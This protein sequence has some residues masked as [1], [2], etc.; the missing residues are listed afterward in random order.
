LGVGATPHRS[1]SSLGVMDKRTVASVRVA[2]AITAVSAWLL[3]PPFPAPDALIGDSYSELVVAHGPPTGSIPTKFVAWQKSRGI[4]IWTLEVSYGTAPVDQAATPRRVS[5]CLWVDWAGVSILC[6][7][8]VSGW[9]SA[10]RTSILLTNGSND[11]AAQ[12]R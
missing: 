4:A 2:L 8:T 10:G 7:R 3:T 12:H 1:I 9:P 11:H 5:R 6:Q